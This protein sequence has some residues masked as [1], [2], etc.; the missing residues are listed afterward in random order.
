LRRSQYQ[1]HDV[2]YQYHHVTGSLLDLGITDK[3]GHSLKEKWSN[4]ILTHLGLMVG[5]LNRLKFLLSHLRDNVADPVSFHLD[6]RWA[7]SQG[8][9]EKGGT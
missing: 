2:L 9:D 4:G 3:D 1:D 8:E 7:V 6:E 5:W